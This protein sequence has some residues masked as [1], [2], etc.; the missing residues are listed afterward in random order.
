M[1]AVEIEEALPDPLDR[2]RP[3]VASGDP[4]QGFFGVARARGGKRHVGGCH[5]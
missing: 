3:A 5:L 2:G 4:L 1:N